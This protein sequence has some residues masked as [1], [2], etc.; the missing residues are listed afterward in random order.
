MVMGSGEWLAGRKTSAAR[1]RVVSR[2]TKWQGAEPAGSLA[3]LF[4]E[5]SAFCVLNAC[6]NVPR[7]GP[8]VKPVGEPDA[9]AP[10]VRFDERRWETGCWP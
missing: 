8:A 7:P 1:L 2:A 4:T 10:H 6:P 9:V 3:R 5:D